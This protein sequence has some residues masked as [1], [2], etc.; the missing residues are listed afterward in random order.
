MNFLLDS[1]ASNSASRFA[2]LWSN[3][4][5][6]FASFD[7]WKDAVD[8]LVLSI[9]FFCMFRFVRGKKGAALIL[10]MGIC[11]FAWFASFQL[12]LDGV[13]FIFSKVFEIGIIALVIIFQPELRDVLE[14]IGSGPLNSILNFGDQKKKQQ[15]YYKAVDDICAAISDLSRTKTGALLVLSRNTVLDDVINTGVSINADVNSFLIRN[16]FFNKAPL[17]DGAVVID[18]ARIVSAG[19]L[20]PLTRRQDI[21]G[22]LGTRHRAA[23]GM[24]EVSDAII[25]V[26]SEETGVISVA[27]DCTLTRNYTPDSLRSLLLKAWVKDKSESVSSTT[28]DSYYGKKLLG[29]RVGTYLVGILSLA[30]AVIF[31]LYAKI[32]AQTMVTAG[33]SLLSGF[34]V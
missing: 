3:I 19:C 1:G 30:C 32:V 25:I 10:G 7:F 20:L 6:A 29:I 17:H 13:Y 18:E 21:D 12:E 28:S 26:V 31:W 2:E 23:V 15:L 34:I 24:S 4:K 22:D 33:L 14:H 9:L 16:L 11:L 5:D 27:S 8:I